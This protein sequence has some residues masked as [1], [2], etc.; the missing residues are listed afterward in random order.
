MAGAGSGSRGASV[1]RCGSG[2]RDWEADCASRGAGPGGPDGGDV[3]G[4]AAEVRETA[5]MESWGADR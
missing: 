5:E 4:L 3:T 2:S 1:A